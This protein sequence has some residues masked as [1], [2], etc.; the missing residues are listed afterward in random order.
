M[1]EANKETGRSRKDIEA[2][3]TALLKYQLKV[4]DITKKYK[5]QQ[6]CNC[7]V[8]LKVSDKF[9]INY[10]WNELVIKLNELE[11]TAKVLSKDKNGEYKFFGYKYNLVDTKLIEDNLQDKEIKK[12]MKRYEAKG[13]QGVI[14]IGKCDVDN[15]KGD[16][17]VI[18]NA[19]KIDLYKDDT[20]ITYAFKDIKDTNKKKTTDTLFECS[21]INIVDILKVTD[22]SMQV[23]INY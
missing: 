15:L 10:F 18:V 4:V 20:K 22:K 3:K 23:L 5:N 13:K 17:K 6:I 14:G 7:L 16:L 21:I 8:K 19:Q 12:K 9:I 1:L 2:Y 11:L